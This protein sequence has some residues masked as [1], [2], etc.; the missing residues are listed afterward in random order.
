MEATSTSTCQLEILEV[1]NEDDSIYGQEYKHPL[2]ISFI[3]R[4]YERNKVIKK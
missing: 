4:L 2:H 3:K 1:I